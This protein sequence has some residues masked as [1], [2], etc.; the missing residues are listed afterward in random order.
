[1]HDPR[2]GAGATRRAGS[3]QAHIAHRSCLA[4]ALA[5]VATVTAFGLGPAAAPIRAQS[6][7]LTLA[8]GNGAWQDQNIEVQ[9]GDELSIAGHGFIA[10]GQVH[11]EFLLFHSLS[12]YDLEPFPVADDLGDFATSVTIDSVRFESRQGS[13]FAW[14]TADPTC[15]DSVGL[16]VLVLETMQVPATASA[17]APNTATPAPT[18]PG[19]PLGPVALLLVAILGATGFVARAWTSTPR[20]RRTA[21]RDLPRLR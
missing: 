6:C 1:M 12:T 10:N 20:R 8:V 17:E 13:I 5:L 14:S 19:S 7:D 2:D 15:V 9:F 4:V 16:V 3:P 11:L 18:R 21:R